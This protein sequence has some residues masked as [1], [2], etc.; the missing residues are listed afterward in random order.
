MKQLIL[1]SL[2]LLTGCFFH[3]FSVARAQEI[4][5]NEILSSNGSTLADQDGDFE[6]WL[7]LFNYGDEAVNL[8]GFGLSDDSG[9]P[10]RW[11]FPAVLMEPGEYLLVWASGKNRKT[12]LELHTNFSIKS[13]G[14]EVI[15]TNPD[16]SVIDSVLPVQIPRDISYGRS[17]DGTGTFIYFTSPTPGKVNLEDGY[18]EFLSPP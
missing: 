2:F 5:I 15:F 8:E 12:E 1:I 9:N 4:A 16:G 14:E 17:P 3:T 11:V 13:A 18:M 7:E 6:D 10:F